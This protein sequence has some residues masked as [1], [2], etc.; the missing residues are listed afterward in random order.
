MY[1]LV[2]FRVILHDTYY[3]RFHD[4]VGWDTLDFGLGVDSHE[5]C[6]GVPRI[7]L[8][9]PLQPVKEANTNKSTYTAE[10]SSNIPEHKMTMFQI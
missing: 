3:Y 9:E 1:Q 2:N 8:F 7:I 6:R 5:K 4:N 10:R